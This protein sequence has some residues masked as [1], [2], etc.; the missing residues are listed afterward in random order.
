MP[1]GHRGS[2]WFKIIWFGLLHNQEN[3]ARTRN[4]FF[5][6]TRNIQKVLC[7]WNSRNLSLEEKIINFKTLAISEV[8]YLSLVTEILNSIDAIQSSQKYS[9]AIYLT[10]NSAHIIW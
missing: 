9:M 10:K 6:P 1:P 3:E 5:V 2:L 7:L 4:N 8:V